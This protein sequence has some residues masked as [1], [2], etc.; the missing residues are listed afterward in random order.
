MRSLLALPPLP[1]YKPAVVFMVLGRIYTYNS[2]LVS[3][4]STYRVADLA[5]LRIRHIFLTEQV[6]I[7]TSLWPSSG[8]IHLRRRRCCRY[9]FTKEHL[10]V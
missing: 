3:L 1:V 7:D 10:N 2:H 4:C 9:H 8:L 6:S 5:Y